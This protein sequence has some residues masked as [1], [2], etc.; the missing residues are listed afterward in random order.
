M[1]HCFLLERHVH[2]LT[3]TPVLLQVTWLPLTRSEAQALVLLARGVAWWVLLEHYHVCGYKALSLQ[4]TVTTTGVSCCDAFSSSSVVSRAFS[5]LYV[6]LKFGH[7]PWNDVLN[8]SPSIFDA[9]GTEALITIKWS[10]CYWQFT[11]AKQSWFW[12]SNGASTVS[13]V[14]HHPPHI[15]RS[16]PR[17]SDT[18]YSVLIL[19][20]RITRLLY[21]DVT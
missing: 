15:T 16:V 11:A 10:A 13:L 12:Q 18:P 5:A 2:N 7:H 6:Y 20:L 3:I 21:S 8:Q 19:W 1:L 14:N 17:H 9:L 4:W